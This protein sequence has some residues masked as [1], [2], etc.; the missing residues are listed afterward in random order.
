M[1]KKMAKNCVF[2]EF[3]GGGSL[4]SQPSGI[5]AILC[6]FQKPFCVEI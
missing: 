3:W 2:N 5:R 6:S 4:E 1:P